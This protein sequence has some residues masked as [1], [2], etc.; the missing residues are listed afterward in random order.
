MHVGAIAGCW[1]IQHQPFEFNSFL[2]MLGFKVPKF[3]LMSIVAANEQQS[4]ALLGRM[5]CMLGQVQEWLICAVNVLSLNA[6]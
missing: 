4:E 5:F 1:E 3:C 2:N 6:L